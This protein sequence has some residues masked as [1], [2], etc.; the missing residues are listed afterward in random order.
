ML[1]C[2]VCGYGPYARQSAVD[3]HVATVHADAPV[4]DPLKELERLERKEAFS[5]PPK[6]SRL[7]ASGCGFYVV[8][9]DLIYR[10]GTRAEQTFKKVLV[11]TGFAQDQYPQVERCTAS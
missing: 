4:L 10:P 1:Q 5:K 11:H 9:K 7:C 3:K 8:E 6:G 2:P